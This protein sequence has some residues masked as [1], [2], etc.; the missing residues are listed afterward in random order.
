M[1]SAEQATIDAMQRGAIAFLSKPISAE[2]L[3][4]AFAGI[5][6]IINRDIGKLLV[7]EDN[8]VL[9]KQVVSLIG[10]GDVE[11]REAVNGR[12][13]IDAIRRTRFD[14][15]VLDLGLPDMS[16]F[17]LLDQLEAE[18]IA[19]PPVVI[20]TGR[21][22]SREEDEKLRHYTESIIIKGVKSVERLLDET[23]LFLHR[24]VEKMPEKKRKM[25]ASLH[26]Q[27]QMFAGKK[28]LLVDDDMRNTFALAKIL[29]EKDF[30]VLIASDGQQA[31]ELLGKT[32]NIDLVLMDIMMPVMDGYETMKRI[33]KQEKLWNLPIIALTAKA[34][35]EDR[36]DCIK[37]GAS[38]YLSKPVD[39]Q[40]LL[41]MMRVWLYR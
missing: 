24:I 5:E 23:A 41:S 2:D 14:C 40:R 26:E 13:A 6:H 15:V 18:N 25:I 37:A 19:I 22:L 11:T 38:D 35:K 1:M 21:D 12:E 20:Y 31:L 33:R 8:D 28:L 16:G 34:M 32:D 9:R 39:M 3:Q 10:D 17:D 36:D 4:S 30:E 7:V 27:D 29:K